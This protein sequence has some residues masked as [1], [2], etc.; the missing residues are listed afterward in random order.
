MFPY[1]RLDVYKIAFEANQ[2]LYRHLKKD[3]IIAPF[4][5][6]QLGRASLST[7]LNIAEGS[8]KYSIRDR[9]NYFIIARASA[10]EC[11]SLLCFLYEEG[12][13]PNDLNSD[14]YSTFDKISIILFTMIRNLESP[15][16]K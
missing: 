3:Q 4:I 12:D 8:A 9:K 14:L 2:K 15:V 16:T 7:M 11:A 13:I 1:E 10:F 6:N 5:K